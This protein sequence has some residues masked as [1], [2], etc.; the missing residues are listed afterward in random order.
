MS[1]GQGPGLFF[2]FPFEG[3]FT[4]LL[5]SSFSP[6]PTSMSIETRYEG[7]EIMSCSLSF[8]ARPGSVAPV[9]PVPARYWL[10]EEPALCM[11]WARCDCVAGERRSQLSYLLPLW[12]SPS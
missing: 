11:C 6:R 4:F 3:Q 9:F 10:R 8:L 12:N 5:C 7:K 2:S 1:E